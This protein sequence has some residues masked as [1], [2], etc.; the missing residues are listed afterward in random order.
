MP[1]GDPVVAHGA[2][3]HSPAATTASAPARRLV[4]L[5][6]VA[7]F[8][9]YVDRGNLST[10]A[11]LIQDQLQLSATQ[12]GVL[13]SAFYYSYVPAMAPVG[14]LAERIGAQRVLAAGVALW[15]VATL[16]T[17][18]AGDFL[19]L[20]LLRLMLG[21]G[22]SAGFPCSS[23]L[24]AVAVPPAQ[25]GSANGMM[26]FGYLLG[27]AAGTVL[28]GMLM[29]Q[30][31][32]R[33][34][35][36]LFGALSLLWLWPWM[37]LRLAGPPVR[38]T[39]TAADGPTFRQILRARGLW[40]TALGHFASNY[41]YYFILAWL[42]LY[43]VKVRGF[44]MQ[45]MAGVAGFAYLINAA[46]A[47][48]SGWATDVWIRSGRSASVAYKS[49][50][51]LAHVA[52]IAAMAGMVLLPVAGSVACLFAYQVVVGLSSP[53]VFAIPQIMAGPTAAGRWVGV[54][55]TC[56]NVAGILAPVITGLLVDATGSFNSAFVLAAAVNVLGLVG[57]L[58]ILPRIAPLRW[59]L[60]AQ[61]P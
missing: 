32:W 22:E 38:I 45:S 50:M 3:A 42:P 34:V 47:L 21:L 10:A 25:I 56:A 20:L 28:G 11:P 35:F 7:L 19:S 16:L 14:W 4:L 17:G 9:N 46:A 26:A 57:W 12:L 37:R 51:V 53:G 6:S 15:A 49:T 48:F 31:G 33:A 29:S 30:F 39:G 13:L 23:K 5:L 41:N 2:A 52:S 8:I 1:Q 58:W 24:V 36:M 27:P 54:Q 43:L 59:D 18:L 44:S 60:A 55:N 40:G 61:R